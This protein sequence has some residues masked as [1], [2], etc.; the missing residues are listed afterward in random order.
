MTD[1][2]TFCFATVPMTMSFEMGQDSNDVFETTNGDTA[3]LFISNSAGFL[4][5]ALKS[6]NPYPYPYF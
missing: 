5:S 2:L 4:E 1:I 3:I 6:V